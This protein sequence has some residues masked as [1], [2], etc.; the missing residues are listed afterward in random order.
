MADTPPP[1]EPSAPGEG[2]T[3]A[4]LA[5]RQE[6]T[7][8]KLDRI[9]TIL[10]KGERGAQGKAQDARTAELDAPTNIAEEIR[11]QFDERDRRERASKEAGDLASWRQ[12]V[13]SAL[14]GLKEQQP[15]PPARRVEKVMGWR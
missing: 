7:D 11:A 2:P 5:A 6:A 14:T 12:G 15:E 1:P 3:L 4:E 13:D 8:D 9:L 10:G